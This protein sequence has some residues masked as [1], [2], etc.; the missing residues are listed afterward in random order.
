MAV[1]AS[2]ALS[3]FVDGVAVVAAVLRPQSVSDNTQAGRQTGGLVSG[4]PSFAR[5]PLSWA[6]F[7]ADFARGAGRRTSQRQR[8]GKMLMVMMRG[9]TE[10]AEARKEGGMVS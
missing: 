5:S 1:A 10:H 7:R 3:L 2:L 8:G 9:G 6:A 4:W